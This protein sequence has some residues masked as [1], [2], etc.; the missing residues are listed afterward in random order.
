MLADPPPGRVVLLSGASSSG[1]SSIAAALLPRLEGPWFLVPVDAIGVMRSEAGT[2]R[3][4]PA[5]DDVLRRT[6]RGYHRA[7]AGLAEAGNDVLMDYPLSEPWRIDDL[8]EVLRG[9]DAVVVEV[10]CDPEEL[11]H[12]ESVRGDRPAGLAASQRFVHE[13]GV[14][15]LVVDA[16]RASA[17]QCADRILTALPSLPRP[18]AL[19]AHRRDSRRDP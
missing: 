19:E 10:R 5:L 13:H 18:R 16:T 17:E 3:G 8:A 11:T 14:H 6:R 4:G 9:V 2:P 12:R 15:D 7:V 1:K